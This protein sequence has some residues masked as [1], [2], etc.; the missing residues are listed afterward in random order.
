MAG[1]A[2]LKIEEAKAGDLITASR[3]SA[4]EFAEVIA[5]GKDVDDLKA[6]DKIFVKAWGID[7]VNH[8]DVKYHFIHKDTNA[9][10]AVI[11]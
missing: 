2:Y 8:N 1:I 10:L 6:G 5:V 7:I 9:I 3:Q 11:K 4:V